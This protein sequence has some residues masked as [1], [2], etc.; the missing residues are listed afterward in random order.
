MD[1]QDR[2]EQALALAEQYARLLKERFHA[3]RV[4][5]FGSLV[6]DGVWHSRSDLDLAVE[7]LSPQAMSEAERQLAQLAPPWLDVDLVALERVYPEVR[8]R[9]LGG[10]PMPENKYLALVSR[11]E[12]ELTGLERVISGLRVALERAGKNPDEFASRALA[13]YV[14]DFYKGC[15]QICER[16]AVTLD[17]GSSFDCAQETGEK[18]H[19]SLLGQMGTEGGGGRPALFG[20][21]LLLELDEYR[22][23]RHR[24]RHIYGY[25]LEAERVLAL[26]RGVE[27]TFPRLREAVRVFSEWLNRHRD[28]TE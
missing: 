20:G 15:E 27:P 26:A 19:Q 25:Q 18:W 24:V 4:V 14:D 21:P 23:F 17:G 13:T 6:G 7:G 28:D 2:R 12:D 22:R 9:I 1:V 10:K 11:L 3:R 8:V 16:V 5:P